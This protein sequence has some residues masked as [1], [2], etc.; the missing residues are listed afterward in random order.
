MGQATDDKSSLQR[1][2]PLTAC[3]DQGP[4]LV[5][6]LQAFDA[7]LAQHLHNPNATNYATHPASLCWG[8]NWSSA[9]EGSDPTRT[10]ALDRDCMPSDNSTLGVNFPRGQIF[11]P[12]HAQLGFCALLK[13]VT[14]TYSTLKTQ[15]KQFVQLAASGRTGRE[16]LLHQ[17]CIFRDSQD[18]VTSC[19][20]R[21]LAIV[22]QAAT[23]FPLFWRNHYA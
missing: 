10:K 5:E 8:D 13:A 6:Y 22:Q 18:K 12:Y 17:T 15:R 20:I 9:M 2:G 16:K 21:D 14:L 3:R 23:P 1:A 7:Y 19:G 4:A 11:P